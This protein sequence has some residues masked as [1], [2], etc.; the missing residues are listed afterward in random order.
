MRHYR[1]GSPEIDEWD[2]WG[3]Y[4]AD[5]SHCPTEVKIVGSIHHV[6]L[7]K[8]IGFCA[9]KS[10]RL[11]I[12]DYMV[13]GSLNRWISAKIKRIGFTWNTRQRIISDI[14]KGLTCL[15]DLVITEKVDVYAFGIVLL[16]ILCGRKNLDWYQADEEDVHLLSI[17]RRK[18]EQEQLMNMVD[19]NKDYNYRNVPKVGTGNQ[20]REA[21]INSKF[22]SILSGPRCLY[23]SVPVLESP[24]P[25]LFTSFTSIKALNLWDVVERGESTVQ[26]LRDNR[27]LNDIKKYDELMTRSPRALTCIHSSITKVMFTRIMACETAKKAWDKITEEFEDKRVKS[28]KVLAL[29]R[30]FELLKIKDSDSVKE[31]SSK[32]VDIVN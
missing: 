24:I 11:L 23:K 27:T 10:E 17:F 26:P 19:R 29:K 28:I 14:A 5:P 13:N 12:Y 25:S 16:K 3:D 21:T 7:V 15:H 31:Y 6:N 8:L 18:A 1:G 32:M 30:E 9:K 2:S 22:P 20:Q 4:D